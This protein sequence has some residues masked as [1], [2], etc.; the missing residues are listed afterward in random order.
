M[1]HGATR[2]D[3]MKVYLDDEDLDGQFQRPLPTRTS[4]ALTSARLRDGRAD[5]AGRRPVLVLAV[6]GGRGGGSG[7]P[8]GS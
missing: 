3:V 5:H 2:E 4:A 8:L 7:Y 1:S 6:V